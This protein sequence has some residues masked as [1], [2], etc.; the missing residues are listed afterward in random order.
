M[1]TTTDRVAPSDFTL[2]TPGDW[3]SLHLP[4]DASVDALLDA[5]IREAPELAPQRATLRSLLEQLRTAAEATGVC[6]AAGVLLGTPGAALPA[7]MT[8]SVHP[9][10]TAGEP[11]EL[12]EQLR[13]HLPPQARSARVDTVDLPAGPAVRTEVIAASG[14]DSGPMS[15]AMS[16]VV[17]YLVKVPGTTRLLVLTFATPAVALLDGLRPLFHAMASTLEFPPPADSPAQAG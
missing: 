12:V 7:T 13:A 10:L 1:T 4:D 9:T 17:Q 2:A 8:V 15:G 5:R 14:P 6:Y 11:T 3:F 16:L